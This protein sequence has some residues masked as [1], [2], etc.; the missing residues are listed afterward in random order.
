MGKKVALVLG[1]TVPHCELIRQLQS[2]GYYTILID[3]L[4]NS[5]AKSAADEHIRESTLDQEKVLQIA[6][7]RNASLVIS[8]CVDQ[9]NI[10]ACYVMEKLG[11][12]VPYSYETAL[13]VANK[14]EM[15][16]IMLE[17][18]IPTSKYIYVDN[19]ERFKGEELR[20][21]V[22]VKPADSNSANGVKKAETMEEM[23]FYLKDALQISR[24]NRAIVEEYI[25][26]VE[27]SAYC[28]I[29]D[30][31]AKLLMTAER[32]SVMDGPNKV[33]KCYSS[34]APARISKE[35]E[36][37]AEEIAT[38]IAD[39]FGLDN[40]P[41]FFQ[42]IVNGNEIDVIEFAPRVG[43]G[44]CF[45]TIKGNTGFDIMAA[46]IDSWV[47]MPVSFE[48]WSYPTQLYIVNTVYGKNG[49]FDRIVGGERLLEEGII[50]ELLS[51]RTPGEVLDSNRASSSRVC[52]FIVKA[53]TEKEMLSKIKMAYD[54][55]DIMDPDA[56][57]LLRKDIS[58]CALWD[59]IS[60]A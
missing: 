37:R 52:F 11:L 60:K 5:P 3:Y 10:T 47:G 25:T 32:I 1:G 39:A 13:K 18:G 59:D 58:L 33:I 48:A 6:K 21:P 54:R 8:G 30:H 19:T 41:F 12:Y 17:N 27:I 50:E 15:K 28:F 16:K 44:S 29:K 45:K 46:T 53:H 55:L 26:G 34:I 31:K 14:G 22:I 57:S 24:N 38:M 51:I 35:A 36:T 4:D 43:G 42:G 23:R 40:I 56:T 49:V 2:R 7:E 20:F 9:A